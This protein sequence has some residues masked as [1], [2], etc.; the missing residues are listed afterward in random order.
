[1]A[2]QIIFMILGCASGGFLLWCL[3]GF[4]RALKQGRKVVG[5]VVRVV[6]ADA[7]GEASENMR[8]N[9][10]TASVIPR[11]RPQPLRPKKAEGHTGVS[12]RAATLVSLAIL[13]G[14]RGG[15]P[16]TPQSNFCDVTNSFTKGL[17]FR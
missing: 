1:M 14:S 13:L 15:G 10:G 17:E 2:R 4:T 6:E 16:G 9:A 5:V 8:R 3:S 7:K 12:M 11:T